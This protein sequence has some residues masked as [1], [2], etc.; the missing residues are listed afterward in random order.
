MRDTFKRLSALLT[1]DARRKIITVTGALGLLLIFLSGFIHSGA[2]PGDTEDTAPAA[3]QSDTAEDYR[4]MLERELGEIVSSIDGAGSVRIMITMDTTTEDIYAV[5]RSAGETTAGGEQSSASR[6]EENE[7][8]IIRG[9]DGSEQVVLKKQRM[10]EIRGVLVVC[11]GGGS[12]VTREKITS[13]VAGA[14][15]IARGKVVVTN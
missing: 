11:D 9:K 2:P 10:P 1:A 15:G 5:D 14:L 12:S 7:Y 13:A 8:V 4:K 3:A 6:S